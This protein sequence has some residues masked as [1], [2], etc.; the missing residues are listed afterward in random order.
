MTRLFVTD[1]DQTF[2]HHDLTFNEPLF[3]EVLDKI[4]AQGDQFAIATGRETKWVQRKFG[5]LADRVHL[6]TNN[7]AAWR[8]QG[9]SELHMKNINPAIL[10]TLEETLLA[11]EPIK[12]VHAYSSEDMYRLG[13]YGDLRPEVQAYAESVYRTI[14]IV[15]HLTDITAPVVSITAAVEV[16]DSEAMLARLRDLKESIHPTT[17]GYGTID[18]LPAN[19]N[20]ATSL[21]ALIHSLGIAPADVTVFGDGM[22]DLEMMQMA[23][24]VYLMPN[25]DERLFGRGFDQAKMDNEQDGVLV[26]LTDILG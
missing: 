20:K 24:K 19:I 22:N 14:S 10:A 21:T 4:T 7:G 25:S 18:I 8:A 15:D 1:L 3:V 11:G 23:G 26:T 2:L 12:G 5:A 6:V 13:G 9:S 16:A 17:S